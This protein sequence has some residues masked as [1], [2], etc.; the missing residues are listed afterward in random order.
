MLK[1][2][3]FSLF[4]ALGLAA[5]FF[6][7]V[8]QAN[9]AIVVEAEANGTAV[10]NSLGT[11]QA[12]PS[13]A[14]TLPVPATVFPNA[15]NNPL[16]PH[17]PTATVTG[18]N[19][20]DDIDF[21]AFT[22]GAGLAYF[23]ID[24]DPFEFDTVLSLFD[25]TGS[26][27]AFDDDSAPDPGTESSDSFLGVFA[28]PTADTYYITVT[29]GNFA[30]QSF[31]GAFVPLTR[32]DGAFGGDATPGRP[33]DATFFRNS[34]QDGSIF[35]LYTLHISLQNPLQQ[36]VV[37]EPAS[38]AVWGGLGFGMLALRRRRRRQVN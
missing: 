3:I 2:R 15:V 17:F 24:N 7:G 22:A 1:Y 21:F 20:A 18:A 25:S 23:D 12:I 26:L 16:L 31:T 34:V 6:G 29:N 13:A 38:L 36:A 8:R 33:V 32:P 19:G 4:G 9:A 14:F 28:L 35:T 10:N 30:T 11:A 5:A 27:L 37:P